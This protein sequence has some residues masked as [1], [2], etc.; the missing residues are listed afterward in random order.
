[1]SVLFIIFL[2][3]IL[4]DGNQEYDDKDVYHNTIN[5]SKYWKLTQWFY[6]LWDIHTVEYYVSIKNYIDLY[7]LICK[8]LYSILSLKKSSCGELCIV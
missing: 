2:R 4:L 1:M 6:K 3:K 5:N 8:V 7:A